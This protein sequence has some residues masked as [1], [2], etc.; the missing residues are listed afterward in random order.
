M[1]YQRQA[2][3]WEKKIQGK[4]QGLNLGKKAEHF[5]QGA[6][7]NISLK[8][9]TGQGRGYQRVHIAPLLLALLFKVFWV[10]LWIPKILSLTF[11]S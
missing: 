3:R 10:F 5:K 9:G 2:G 4:I 8:G 7:R 1:T 6:F 11:R